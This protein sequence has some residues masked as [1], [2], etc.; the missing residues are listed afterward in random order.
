MDCKIDRRYSEKNIAKKKDIGTDEVEK[1]IN[2]LN[3]EDVYRRRNPLL[4]R[5]T[6]FKP[7]SKTASRIDFWLSEK[8]LDPLITNTGIKHA[9]RTDHASIE[10]IIKTSKQEKGPGYWK[11]NNSLLDSELFNKTFLAFWDGWKNNINKYKSKREWWEVTK[12]KIKNIAIHVSKQISLKT[13]I[14]ASILGK[15]LEQLKNSSNSNE[16]EIRKV[17]KELNDLWDKKTEGARIRAGAEWHEKGEKSTKYFFNLEKIKAQGKM[18]TQIKDSEGKIKH[19]IENILEE[20][21]KYYSNLLTSEGWNEDE[22]NKLLKNIEKKLTADEK[23]FCDKKI[24][25]KE[26]EK[27]I[28]ALKCYKSPGEDGITAEVYKKIWPIIKP[29]FMQVIA[30]IEENKTLC[31]SM[32]RGIIALLYKCGHRDIIQNWRPITLLNIDYKI[33]AKIFAERLK[34]VLPSIISTDQK[35]C[36]QGRQITETIRLI[37]DI[38]DKVDEDDTEGAIIFL[39]QQKAFDR[40][41]WGYLDACLNKFGFGEYFCEAIKMLYKNAKSCINTNGH[42]SK[43]FNVTRSMRQGCPIAAFLYI[44]QAEPM[45][46]TIRKS[47]TIEGIKISLGNNQQE[48]RVASFADDTQLFHR[49]EKSIKEGFKILEIYSKAS[50]AKLN[51]TKTKGLYIGQWKNKEPVFKDIKWVKNV[52]GL[53]AEFGYEINYED[54]WLQKFAKFKKKITRWKDRDLTL[55]GKKILINSYILSSISYLAE[56]YSANVPQVFIKETNNLIREFLWGGKT[57][58][59]A[60]KNLA[61]KKEHGGLEIPDI[62]AYIQSKKIKWVLRI[63]FSETSRWNML[64]K[65][66]LRLLDNKFGRD[67]FIL[68]CSSLTGLNSDKLP[69]FYKECLLSWINLKKKR[70]ITTKQDVLDENLFGNHSLIH[71]DKPVLFQHWSKA[72][73]QKIND[74]WDEKQN[75]WITSQE[76]LQKL[77]IQRN[78]MA[79][80]YRL[81]QAIPKKWVQLLQNEK[82]EEQKEPLYRYGKDLKLSENIIL[83]NNSEI[84]PQK[85]KSK[86]IYYHCL[87]PVKIPKFIETW[88][89]K[90]NLEI[91]WK[92]IFNILST[93]IQENKQKQLHWKIIHRAIYTESKLASMGKSNGICKLCNDE[94]EDLQHLFYNCKQINNIWRS[95]ENLISNKYGFDVLFGVC[96]ILFGI[97]EPILKDYNHLINLAILECKWQIWKNRNNVKFGKK[98]SLSHLNIF[99]NVK[100]ACSKK[101]Q[102]VSNLLNSKKYST[103]KK[104]IESEDIFV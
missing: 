53:G 96:N 36:I 80:Y 18:W 64:G 86:E 31:D 50:G 103:L 28:M 75:S 57:W 8:T 9:V 5:Y 17:E 27:S 15:K 82:I 6:Y 7:N 19:G 12:Y 92:E 68:S 94:V 91:N 43:Y 69:P 39:D 3:L 45:S 13:K 84:D 32:Y 83:V 79:E 61:M 55:Y 104:L 63:R 25:E 52:S 76:L 72:G 14:Q 33:I 48:V 54:L 20:Q 49:S 60:Q 21:V 89:T 62:D 22:A 41:E 102:L 26:V 99:E 34:K 24:T 90:L 44:L 35:A 47:E 70:I 87:Y 59:V 85:F 1:I 4:R 29:E 37:Q 74:I 42:L 16:D 30:E 97:N 73:L 100:Y 2:N 56:I 65:G 77:N 71:N 81:K 67:F 98:E 46:E 66:Y 23:N 93:S 88:E 95:L 101:L 58:K 10:C 51:M 38:I 78:W 40:V 11:F